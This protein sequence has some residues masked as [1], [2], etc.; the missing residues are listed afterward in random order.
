MKKCERPRTQRRVKRD[1]EPT[2]KTFVADMTKNLRMNRTPRNHGVK[3]NQEFAQVIVDCYAEAAKDTIVAKGRAALPNPGTLEL[4]L[5]PCK[6]QE[7]K[8]Q[9]QTYSGGPGFLWIPKNTWRPS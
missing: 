2:K 7:H 6:S 8:A 3:I 9:A 4:Q 5:R 1:T